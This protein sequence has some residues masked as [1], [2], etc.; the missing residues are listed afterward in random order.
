MEYDIIYADPPWEYNFHRD[1]KDRPNATHIIENQYPTM[2]LDKIKNMNIPAK[3][4]SVLFLWVTSP[5][6]KEGIEVMDSWN[7]EY[8]TSIIWDKKV[9]GM[10]YW[11]R[12]SHEII[13]IGRRGKFPPPRI[14]KPSVF[15]FKKTKH[16]SKPKFFYSL[17]DEMF[18][19]KNKIELFARDRREG[20]SSHGNQLGK[21]IQKRIGVK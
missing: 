12:N 7:F 13:L 9:M 16:S 17:I 6:L 19:N 3:K 1:I 21:T 4:N 20:W 5:K 2:S 10:G 11:L 8:V 15:R 18:P 14:Q